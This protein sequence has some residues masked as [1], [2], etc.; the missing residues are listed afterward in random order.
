MPARLDYF[1]IGAA[2][3]SKVSEA[4]QRIELEP[5]LRH[6]VDMRA[7][8]LNGCTFCIDLHAKQARAAGE[9][10]WR[11][12]AVSAWE[13]S[14]LFTERERAALAWTDAVT[15]LGEGQVPDEVYQRALEHFS[16]REVVELTMAIGL[17]NLWNRV[18]IAFRTVPGSM[19]EVLLGQRRGATA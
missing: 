9:S 15:R 17:I 7:S 13:K 14:P 1:K 12:Y 5:T 19:D 10:E 4:S 16:E 3:L 18:A 11:L 8:Q 2:S 6:L